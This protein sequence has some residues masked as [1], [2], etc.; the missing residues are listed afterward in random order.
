MTTLPPAQVARLGL[1]M[2]VTHGPDQWVEIR[3][4]A[5]V[6]RGDRNRMQTAVFKALDLDENGKARNVGAAAVVSNDLLLREW[7]VAWSL[8][9]EDG[10]ALPIPRDLTDDEFDDLDLDITTAIETYLAPVIDK[11]NQVRS[12]QPSTDPMSPFPGTAPDQPG[13]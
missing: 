3:N 12:T 6:T 4:P 8:T 13:S 1:P 11:I 10:A 9:R 7:V 5:R 2:T